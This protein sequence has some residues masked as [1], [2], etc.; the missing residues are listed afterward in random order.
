MRK[1]FSWTVYLAIALWK[2]KQQERSWN[3]LKCYMR[4]VNTFWVKI[5]GTLTNPR[6]EPASITV[7]TETEITFAGAADG[8]KAASMATTQRHMDLSSLC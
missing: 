1:S 6:I 4:V 3:H 8:D 5:T 2:L 7:K